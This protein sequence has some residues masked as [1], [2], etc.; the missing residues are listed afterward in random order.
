MVDPR[1]SKMLVYFEELT[2]PRE[3]HSVAHKTFSKHSEFE[4]KHLVYRVILIFFD[5]G[6]LSLFRKYLIYK[7][8]INQLSG[9][10]VVCITFWPC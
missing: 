4:I 5:R 6:T 8:Q 7:T 1:R 9:K 2:R 3:E 10:L